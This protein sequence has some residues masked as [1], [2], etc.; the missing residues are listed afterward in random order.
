M[1]YRHFDMR[2]GFFITF[3]GNWS[4][5]GDTTFQSGLPNTITCPAC[6]SNVFGLSTGTLFP[7]VVGNLSSLLRSGDPQNFTDPNTANN[8]YYDKTVL[9]AASLLPNG[10]TVSGLNIFGGA[11]SDTFTIGGPGSGSHVGSFFGNL[12]AKCCAEPRTAAATMGV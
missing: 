7:Q 3:W 8:G 5:G 1:T 10:T 9:G 11:G 12:G 6:L 4:I 2:V